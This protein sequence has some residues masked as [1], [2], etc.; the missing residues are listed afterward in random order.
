MH[1]GEYKLILLLVG[2]LSHGKVAKKLADRAIDL[3]EDVQNLRKAIYPCVNQICVTD[4]DLTAGG[5]ELYGL[6]VQT[7]GRDQRKRERETTETDEYGSEL[8][9]R[10]GSPFASDETDDCLGG[11]SYRYGMLIVF[12]NYLIE[13]RENTN[14]EDVTFEEW[15]E[16]HREIAKLLQRRSL[17]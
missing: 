15:M 5:G 17:D 9:V 10:P 8:S 13:M 14:S 2:V 12:S 16:E 6:K 11:A 4:F 3:M 7:E 1:P